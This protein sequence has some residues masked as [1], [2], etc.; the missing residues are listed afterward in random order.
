MDYTPK[1]LTPKEW[2]EIVKIPDV[3]EGFGLEDEEDE[4][5]FKSSAYAV[6]FNYMSD[7]PGY[8][9]DLFVLLGGVPECPPMV[10]IRRGDRLLVV[11]TSKF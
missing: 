4:K 3:R 6:R 9:G 11:D 10:I 7:G 5:A 2:S 1:K 8:A